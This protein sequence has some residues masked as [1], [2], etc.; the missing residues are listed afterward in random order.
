MSA[1]IMWLLLKVTCA[2]QAKF[3]G[4]N[5]ARHSG[6]ALDVQKM[7]MF[8]WQSE[9]RGNDVHLHSNPTQTHLLHREYL[10]KKEELKDTSSASILEKYGGEQYLQRMPKEL[11]GG[12]T[13][14]YVEY[15]RTGQVTKGQE[16]AKAKSKY[17]EDGEF[18]ALEIPCRFGVLTTRPNMQ[19]ILATTPR[20]GAR[21]IRPSL[22]NG[23]LHVATRPSKTRTAPGRLVSRLQRPKNEAV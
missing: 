19:C 14:N 23:G 22:A 4:D 20:C 9:S 15:S 5:F 18:G 1:Q 8:A 10:K 2:L 11:L 16:R 21:G 17:E 7:Q 12:Q 6:N 13:E 3:A